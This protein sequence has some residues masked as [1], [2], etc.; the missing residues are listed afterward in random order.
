M[1]AI[2]KVQLPLFSAEGHNDAMIYG[3]GHWRQQI[4]PL[5]KAEHAMMNG[6]HKAYFRA[7]WIRKTWWLKERV[8]EQAW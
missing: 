8:P 5:T 6:D 1:K 2:V 7:S 3:E 4:R